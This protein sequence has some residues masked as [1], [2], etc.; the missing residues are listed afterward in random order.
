MRCLLDLAQ[1]N[2]E[3]DED[4]EDHNNTTEEQMINDNDSGLAF[5]LEDAVTKRRRLRLEG[6][7]VL[8]AI[9][10]NVIERGFFDDAY[11]SLAPFNEEH[12]LVSPPQLTLLKILDA[13]LQQRASHLASS[14]EKTKIDDLQSL[15]EAFS[16]L[17]IWAQ[18]SM[19]DVLDA[20]A[21]D[22]KPDARLVEVH[23]GL[24]LLCQCLIQL[25]MSIVSTS[26]P[27]AAQA[28]L[29]LMRTRNFVATLISE[30]FSVFL[31]PSKQPLDSC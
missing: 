11:R 28:I 2:V 19:Q 14:S 12:S 18:A 6:L 24:V 31:M 3:A 10:D 17:A 16:K 13:K 25:C 7:G 4:D 9:F 21:A 26:A 22:A 15:S 27:S 23:T 30:F 29:R 20:E 1:S 5:S 8:F